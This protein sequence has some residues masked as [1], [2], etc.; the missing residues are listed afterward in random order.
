MRGRG[1]RRRKRKRRRQRRKEEEE[2]GGGGG[3]EEEEEEE[4]KRKRKRRRRKGRGRRRRRGGGEEEEKR[5]RKRRRRRR[6]RRRRRKKKRRGRGKGGG[7][8]TKSQGVGDGQ[9]G[10]GDLKTQNLL[11]G[12][13]LQGTVEKGKMATTAVHMELYH[14]SEVGRVNPARRGPHF[15]SHLP[16]PTVHPHKR[17]REGGLRGSM[18]GL[19][20]KFGMNCSMGAVG[21]PPSDKGCRPPSDKGCMVPG[22][23]M[24]SGISGIWLADSPKLGTAG[25][26]PTG[27]APTGTCAAGPGPTCEGAKWGKF[28]L[29]HEL[30]GA[31]AL[32][33]AMDLERENL[34]LSFLRD[35]YP[36]FTRNSTHTS[37]FPLPL[38]FPTTTLTRIHHFLVIGLKSPTKVTQLSLVLKAGLELTVTWPASLPSSSGRC[39]EPTCNP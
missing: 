21:Q 26:P 15:P 34:Q 17:E 29:A 39:Q 30:V 23:A 5:K 20:N 19:I 37:L 3:E 9:S 22:T 14:K 10:R 13:S 11:G 12:G 2:E 27:K 24:L 4:E 31:G 36:T 28:P 8:N 32:R 35:F 6:G 38:V 16:I 7:D 18:W 1:G 33:R 25:S